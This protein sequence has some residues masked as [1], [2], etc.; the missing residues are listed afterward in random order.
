MVISDRP[1][2]LQRLDSGD[3]NIHNHYLCEQHF[4]NQILDYL[5]KKMLIKTAK[6]LTM[7]ELKEMLQ[8]DSRYDGKLS[9]RRYSQCNIRVGHEH[10][11]E[12]TGTDV[13]STKHD[14]TTKRKIKDAIGDRYTFI[15]TY[16]LFSNR[17][18]ESFFEFF[19][20]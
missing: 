16:I 7:A 11:D 3:I 13:E 14:E 18:N 9:A 10:K 8:K 20:Q 2:L 5:H 15:L 6:P 17:L 4:P 1:D 19:N 12:I